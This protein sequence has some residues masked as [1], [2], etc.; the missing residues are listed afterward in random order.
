MAFCELELWV[1]FNPNPESLVIHKWNHD[2][3]TTH[4]LE[5]I[6]AANRSMIR[7]ARRL[8]YENCSDAY[9]YFIRNRIIISVLWSAIILFLV[10]NLGVSIHTWWN[11]TEEELTRRITVTESQYS[12]N[13]TCSHNSLRKD[14][15]IQV[16]GD[17]SKSKTKIMLPAESSGNLRVVPKRKS[18][19]GA[20][21]VIGVGRKRTREFISK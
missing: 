9:S 18:T 8:G 2:D 4:T 7:W 19:S 6:Q 21:S 5:E 11:E 16:L 15:I 10:V 13:S 14:Q 1:C 17:S 20:V 3:L 12:K